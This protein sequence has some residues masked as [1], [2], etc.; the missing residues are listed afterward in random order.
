MSYFLG[1]KSF[2]ESLKYLALLHWGD[3]D[4]EEYKEKTNNNFREYLVSKN[5][6]LIFV[7]RFDLTATPV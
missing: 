6:V 1:I 3:I 4:F 5:E 7:C 2:L